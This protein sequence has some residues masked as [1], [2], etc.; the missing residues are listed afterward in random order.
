MSVKSFGNMMIPEQAT[1]IWLYTQ[2]DVGSDYICYIGKEKFCASDSSVEELQGLRQRIIQQVDSLDH[3]IVIDQ[4]R[5]KIFVGV[6]LQ[7]AI[8]E[9]AT[10]QFKVIDDVAQLE[11]ILQKS[12][13]DPLSW[14]CLESCTIA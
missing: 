11:R 1:L 14:A 9:M 3:L 2:G 10:Y 5:N 12:I 4:S 13:P 8:R 7:D 6:K